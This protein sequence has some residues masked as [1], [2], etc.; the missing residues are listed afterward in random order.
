MAAQKLP[1]DPL[2]PISSHRFAELARDTD[3]KPGRIASYKA[4]AQPGSPNFGA[5][6]SGRADRGSASQT[7]FPGETTVRQRQ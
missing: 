4:Q 3:S 5:F 6:K 1:N 2:D 7:A